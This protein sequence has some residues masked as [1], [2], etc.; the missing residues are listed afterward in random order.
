M[1]RELPPGGAAAEQGAGGTGEGARALDAGEVSGDRFEGDGQ[2][3]D[4]VP[5]E[6]DR[7]SAS[8]ERRR[9]V[10]AGRS[11]R[12]GGLDL[13]GAR[14]EIVEAPDS[15][16]VL[17][18]EG[19]AP[20]KAPVRV[21]EDDQAVVAGGQGVGTVEA[22]EELAGAL[23]RVGD[24]AIGTGEEEAGPQKQEAEDGGKGRRGGES[25]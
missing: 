7:G 5:G 1:R 20:E 19:G 24:S 25:T 8:I 4:P 2:R 16:R 18:S 23:F 3:G 6:G 21:E 22:E 11:S 14:G 9:I 10:G 13:V 12:E 17:Q 15:G